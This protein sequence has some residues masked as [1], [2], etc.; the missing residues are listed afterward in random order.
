MYSFDVFND[1]IDQFD[2]ARL[3]RKLNC[4]TGSKQCGNACIP[5]GNKCRASWNKPVKAAAVT[6]GAAGLGLVGTAFLH[7]RQG[8]RHA[9]R[10]AVEPITQ[11]GFAAGNLA[12]GNKTG[13]M[14]N[15]ANVLRSSRGVG[16]DLKFI[17]RGYGRDLKS[18][19]ELG[20]NRY[21]KARYHKRAKGGRVPGLNY[22][23][24]SACS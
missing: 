15:M 3:D 7:K 19:L 21:F 14:K 18:A 5:K 23:G 9:A 13:A 1:S 20:K 17:A 2:A 11:A 8:M 22:D 4:G 10:Q 16:K 12:R 24:D 6:A